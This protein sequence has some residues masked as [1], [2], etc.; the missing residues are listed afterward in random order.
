MAG[1][2]TLP[3]TK[4]SYRTLAA[5]VPRTPFAACYLFL[6]GL[7]VRNFVSKPLGDEILYEAMSPACK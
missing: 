3:T 2:Y 4:E 5:S 1:P 6:I 7:A